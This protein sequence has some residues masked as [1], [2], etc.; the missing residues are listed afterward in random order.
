MA[1]AMR[2]PKAAAVAR[3]RVTIYASHCSDG[4][5]CRH[6]HRR[7]TTRETS[8]ALVISLVLFSR[9]GESDPLNFTERMRA[10]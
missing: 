10:K 5:A 9:I 6:R 7:P 4:R 8:C 2:L 1:D 3:K